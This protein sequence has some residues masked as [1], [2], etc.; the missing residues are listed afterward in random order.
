MSEVDTAVSLFSQ[1]YGCSQ[2]VLMAFA[3][4][5]G[6]DIALAARLASPFG[7]GIARQGETCG[8]VTCAVMVM[9]LRHGNATSAEQAAKEA[10]YPK[11]RALMAAFAEAHGSVKCRGLIGGHDLTT[12]E[13]YAAASEAGVFRTLCPNFVRTAAQLTEAAIA[14][15]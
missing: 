11:V 7:A 14:D 5:F 1:G 8:A 10:M 15:P 13:G 2:S 6:M 3:P 9:G 12:P 4:R